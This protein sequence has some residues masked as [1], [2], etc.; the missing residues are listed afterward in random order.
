MELV[1]ALNR[2]A[3]LFDPDILIRAGIAAIAVSVALLML[4]L[5]IN[6]LAREIHH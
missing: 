1:D 4:N 5:L 6:M 2:L 3:E